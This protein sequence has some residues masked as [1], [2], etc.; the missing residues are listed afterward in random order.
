M[1]VGIIICMFIFADVSNSIRKPVEVEIKQ[2]KHN[3]V[4][5]AYQDILEKLINDPIDRQKLRQAFKEVEQIVNKYHPIATQQLKEGIEKGKGVIAFANT[6][7]DTVI[8]NPEDRAKL[9]SALSTIEQIILK[10]YPAAQ[11]IKDVFNLL[12]K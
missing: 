8:K 4:F 11:I 1:A 12:G 5:V 3:I 7:L 2:Q 9:I 6:L 10:H